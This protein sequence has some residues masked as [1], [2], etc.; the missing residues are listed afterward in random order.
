[1]TI[2][3]TDDRGTFEI[4]I[5]AGD[6]SELD[7]LRLEAAAGNRAATF[8]KNALGQEK[9]IELI[10]EQADA[11]TQRWKGWLEE[12][13]GR[14]RAEVTTFHVTGLAPEAFFGYIAENAGQTLQFKMH[15]EHY[16]SY[17]ADG[18]GGE[19]VI[20]EPWGSA[21]ILSYAAFGEP[22]LLRAAGIDLDLVWEPDALYRPAAVGRA[23]DGTFLCAVMHQILPLEGGFTFKTC[24]F[25]PEAVPADVLVG[26]EEH[27]LVEFTN[28][29]RV[30][31][32]AVVTASTNFG[33]DV[34]AAPA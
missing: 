24:A 29:I 10:Q 27:A 20:G 3:L 23:S 14:L 2:D 5:G 17:F 11:T 33:V 34:S 19:S 22:D 13:Q 1:M 18:L 9:L 12:C 15:P 28:M 4:R 7:I 21:M 31:R 6:L 25:L 16:V 26:I 8:L 32:D 30:A